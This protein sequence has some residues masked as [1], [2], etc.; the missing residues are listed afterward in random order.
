MLK[1]CTTLIAFCAAF[2]LA[3]L[4]HAQQLESFLSPPGSLPT[5]RLTT[6]FDAEFKRDFDGRPERFESTQGGING[7]YSILES[8][9]SSVG[10]SAAYE[11]R[12]FRSGGIL[13]DRLQEANLTLDARVATSRELQFYAQVGTDSR[14]DGEDVEMEDYALNVLA[15]A[16]YRFNERWTLIG[17]LYFRSKS[18]GGGLPAIPLP[19]VEAIYTPSR[20]LVVIFGLP[21]NGVIYSPTPEWSLRVFAFFPFNISAE[22]GYTPEGSDF[23]FSASFG[24]N[25]GSY[26]LTDENVV[27][28][29]WRIV[30]QIVEGTA[31]IRWR[32]NSTTTLSLQSAYQFDHRY[33]I[34][35]QDGDTVG[36]H[37][38]VEN[39]FAIR[40]NLEFRFGQPERATPT[41]G[42][43]STR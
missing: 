8:M 39:G 3:S 43:P 20:D 25:S 41:G 36:Q 5:L 6:S 16:G 31:S 18:L 4:L 38:D 24:G 26:E 35:N 12:E 2:A 13:P 7:R 11:Q 23:S 29:D 32:A 27:P 9:P 17:G 14:N 15:A 34:V 19:A 28:D 33:T 42:P 40:L 21:L 1:M 30:R 37:I 10:I 22:A